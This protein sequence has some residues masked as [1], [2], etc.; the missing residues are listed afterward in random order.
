MDDLDT[1]LSLP[2]GPR[3]KRFPISAQHVLVGILGSFLTV[4]A[5]WTVTVEDPY[6]GEPIATAS[7]PV[8]TAAKTEAKP[9]TDPTEESYS[10]K[11]S[12]PPGH[13]ADPPGGKTITIIDGTS[14]K[15][16]QVVIPGSEEDK[17]GGS[18]IDAQLLE[19]AIS[20]PNGRACCCTRQTAR[21][22]SFRR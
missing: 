2:K 1:P 17:Q 4:F 18:G 16:Q 11:P 20:R 13:D 3:R 15:R 8:R 9:G 6:G 14:G 21:C 7:I 12:G 22:S 5:V 10:G 19:A